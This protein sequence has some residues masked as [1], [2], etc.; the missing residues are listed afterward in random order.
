[1]HMWVWCIGHVYNIVNTDQHLMAILINT[2]YVS[3]MHTYMHACMHACMYVSNNSDLAPP[4]SI[5]LCPT[6]QST[7]NSYTESSRYVDSLF[8]QHISLSV[9]PL[10]NI[11]TANTNTTAAS[12]VRGQ[13]YAPEHSSNCMVAKRKM[14]TSF[15]HFSCL[16]QLPQRRQSYVPGC[17]RFATYHK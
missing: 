7:C 13:K 6:A 3:C 12:Y 8:P 17:C 1:M 2:T 5:S 4:P 15:S 16:L 9:I 10:E 14:P 11:N